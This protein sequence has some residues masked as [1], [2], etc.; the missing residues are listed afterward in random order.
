MQNKEQKLITKSKLASE[1]RADR[2]TIREWLKELAPVKTCGKVH[3]YN[4]DEARAIVE[5]KRGGSAH[6]GFLRDDV[7]QERYRKLKAENDLAE[8]GLILH[9]DAVKLA[10]DVAGA[11]K[12][13]LRK[14]ILGNAVQAFPADARA[15]ATREFERAL[16]PAFAA[17]E[18][19]VEEVKSMGRGQAETA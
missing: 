1:Y 15:D 16:K 6:S 5:S 10:Q 7:L 8:D 3:Y 11:S 12:D 2:R 4:E 14:H 19:Y 17:F 18:Q 13:I 9:T